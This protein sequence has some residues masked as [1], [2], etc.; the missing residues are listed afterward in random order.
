M[1]LISILWT[2]FY[3]SDIIFGKYNKHDSSLQ[4]NMQHEYDVIEKD[5]PNITKFFF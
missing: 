3:N 1:D 2:N 4:D 5:A